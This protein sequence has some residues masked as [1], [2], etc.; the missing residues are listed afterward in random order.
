MQTDLV[1]K[2]NPPRMPSA[3]DGLAVR[4]AYERIRRGWS[5]D[6]VARRMTEAGVP[7]N[8]SAI[9]RIENAT[10]RRKITFD[11]AV[12]FAK[13]FGIDLANLVGGKA[14]PSSGILDQI[15]AQAA[16]VRQTTEQL[17]DQWWEFVSMAGTVAGMDIEWDPDPALTRAIQ[18]LIAEFYWIE[19]F[20]NRSS[21]QAGQ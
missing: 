5:A 1:P 19:D 3:E 7:V 4:I 12:G 11:E 9:W 17:R 21:A 6:E 18:P 8:P 10:P 14:D 15:L 20:V 16:K 2:Q 13:V